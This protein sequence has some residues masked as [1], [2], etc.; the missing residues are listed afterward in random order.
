MPVTSTQHLDDQPCGL[1]EQKKRQTRAAM[2]RAALELVAEHGMAHV[3][4]EDIAQRAGVSA[5]TF[6]NYWPTKEAAV[7]GV[8]PERNDSLVAWMR[9]RPA[10]EDV[11]AS[12]R[13]TIRR[14]LV[15]LDPDPELRALKRAVIAG[16]PQL[17]LVSLGMQSSLITDLSAVIAERLEGE[18]ADERAYA[19]VSL[20]TGAA[21]AAFGMSMRNGTE[22][23][24]E[25]ER[26]LAW[27]D[28]GQ[29]G[30]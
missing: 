30:F 29:V 10:D 3:T 4:A 17:H 8:D 24:T 11:I 15:G 9:A 27:A 2:H 18:D 13:G 25:Y 22:V 23:A 16:H 21:R 19:I 26:L 14:W 12:L 28:D 7:L 5:R 6:F 20:A 1:R